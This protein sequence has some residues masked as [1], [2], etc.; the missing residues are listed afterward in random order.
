MVFNRLLPYLTTVLVF[1]AL[2][3][4]F[5]N[6][7][8]IYFIGV[9]L[10]L[11]IWFS[12][13]KLTG[14]R[15]ITQ[16]A[17]WNF[18][19]IPILLILSSGLVLIF[20]EASWLRHLLAILTAFGSGLF[21]EALFIYLYEHENYQPGSLETIA[22]L[23]NLAAFYF[24]V[25]G[26]YGLGIFLGLPLWSQILAVLPVILLSS[27]AVFWFNKIPSQISRR[28][29]LV[30]SLILFELFLAV[31]N[32]PTSFYVDGFILVA[33]DYLLISLSLDQ[34]LGRL[35]K[36]TVARYLIIGLVVVILIL[37]TAQ[38]I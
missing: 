1:A 19:I 30:V 21:L 28:H 5:S 2:E 31:V 27:Y 34:L 12:V 16:S 33:A 24:Y 36:L 29:L 9:F 10:I 3:I 37:A 26:I 17:Q 13:W 20:I 18:L 8:G 32:L 14:F 11:W 25:S 4:I 22:G 15:S 35:K 7:A 23:I 38:W 6:P